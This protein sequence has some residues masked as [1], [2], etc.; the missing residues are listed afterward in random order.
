MPGKAWIPPSIQRKYPVGMSGA[1]VTEWSKKNKNLLFVAGAAIVAFLVG[2]Y[3]WDRSRKNTPLVTNNT[4]GGAQVSLPGAEKRQQRREERAAKKAEKKAR[5]DDTVIV[6]TETPEQPGTMCADTGIPKPFNI[7]SDDLVGVNDVTPGPGVAP[8]SDSNVGMPIDYA[9]SC[10]GVNPSAVWQSST[11]LPASCGQ[12]LEGTSDW[13]IYAP[14]NYQ[15]TS[16]LGA[17]QNFGQDTVSTTL[18]NASLD[19]RPEPAIP[20]AGCSQVPFGQSSWVDN[21]VNR[22]DYSHSLV[23]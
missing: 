21:G 23:A 10:S 16:F 8:Y 2:Y 17:G 13:N 1:N 22:V 7:Y 19:I 3:L 5:K 6:V 14:S 4:V 9:G 18:K 11:L 15:V 20:Q 12:S